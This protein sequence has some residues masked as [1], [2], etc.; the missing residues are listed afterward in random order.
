MPEVGAPFALGGAPLRRFWR[1]ARGFW[2]G[3]TAGIAWGLIGS[4]AVC[5]V[6]QLLVQYRLNLWNRDFF[7]AL[8]QRNG[9][10]IWRQAYLLMEFAAMSVSLA[11]FA[12]WG[13][14]TFQ[15]RWREW[16]SR[17]LIQGWLAGEHYRRI[18]QMDGEH[19]NA[20]YRI[21][22]DARLATDAPIDLVVG[23]L[24]AVLAAG[25][26]VIVLWNVGG[27]LDV[28]ML[29][30]RLRIPGYLVVAAV[31][32][33][34]I[35]TGGMMWVARNMVH[36]IER[37]NQ[38]ESEL[39]YAVAHLRETAAGR[40]PRSDG[41]GELAAIVWS[42]LGEV[43]RQWRRLCGQHMRTTLV[44]SG[45]TLLA[46]L[47]GL[48]LCVPK[49]VHG[50]MQLGEVTQAAAAFFAVQGSFNWLVD[51]YPRLAEC[52]SSANRVG[53]LLIAFDKLEGSDG[54]AAPDGPQEG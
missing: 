37:K 28:G 3:E 39:K 48:I 53:I 6:L 27:A 20:E 44:S 16:V 19:Q 21:S 52:L 54:R 47:I 2:R 38:A 51:N 14:M 32:Y 13:R 41:I 11:I 26:F 49:Y 18:D 35:T 25:T 36:V 43:I 22:E 4:L 42:A 15:R 24:A 31:I 23:L 12:V 40:A 1:N 10:E 50:T 7:N 33:S 9:L 30:W 34:A 29:G 5:V 17:D 46:P 45:N 8:E